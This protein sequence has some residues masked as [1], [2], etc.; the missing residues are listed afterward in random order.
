MILIVVI[1]NILS[2]I[3]YIFL[4]IL[5]VFTPNNIK[6]AQRLSAKLPKLYNNKTIWIHGAS[7]GEIVSVKKLINNIQAQYLDSD[8]LITT[9]T[10]TSKNMI[11]QEFK[12]SVHYSFLPL[13]SYFTIKKFLKHFNPQ[14]CLWVEQDFFP[15]IL[16]S[17]KTHNIPLLLLNARMSDT[18]FKRWGLFPALIAK[19]L[20]NFTSIYA[21][22]KKDQIKLSDLAKKKV[23]YI[24]NLKYSN[25][26]QPSYDI[27][28]YNAIKAVLQNNKVWLALSTHDPEEKD[29][30]DTHIKLKQEFPDIV[31]FIMPRHISRCATIKR[32]LEKNTAINLYSD[33]I[34]NNG[35]F[36]DIVLVN[37]MGNSL[38]FCKLA[39][40]VFIGKSLYVHNKGGHNLLEP[41][42]VQTPVLFGKYMNNFQEITDE[43]CKNKAGFLIDN[44]EDLYKTIQ[45]LYENPNLLRD[46]AKNTNFINVLGV[47]I[48][49]NYMEE[50]KCYLPLTL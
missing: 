16:Q 39:N 43:C 33:I 34:N 4:K 13:D 6:L 24:G 41:L 8:V 26:S 20:A 10:E 9:H 48:L 40:F 50:V 27:A 42:S 32:N 2:F 15:I 46:T 19:I 12:G 45:H 36:T 18:S 28:Q 17:I 49:N 29:I 30:V 5:Y 25:I 35:T 14:L 31:T 38:L 47:D 23:Q 11:L 1:Y 22:S 3:I 44:A 7:V 21:M 37:T